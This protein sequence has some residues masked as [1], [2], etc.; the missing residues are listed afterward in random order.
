MRSTPLPSYQL[1]GE[2]IFAFEGRVSGVSLREHL[3]FLVCVCV[4]GGDKTNRL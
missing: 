1:I 2:T 4:C 3:I